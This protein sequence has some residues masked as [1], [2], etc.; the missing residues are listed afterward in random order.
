MC[1]SVIFFI[2]LFVALIIFI[3]IILFSQKAASKEFKQFKEFNE[4][5]KKSIKNEIDYYSKM[6]KPNLKNKKED[7]K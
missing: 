2:S 3:I 1:L 6:N 4:A 7:I 5:Y